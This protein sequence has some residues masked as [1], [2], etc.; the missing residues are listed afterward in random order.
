VLG[1]RYRVLERLAEGGMGTVYSAEHLTLHKQVALKLVHE[2][3]NADHAR[4]FVREAMVTSRIDHPNVISALDFGTFEDGTAYL[5]MQLVDGPTL[6][7]VLSAEGCLSWVRAAE[8]GAQLADALLAAQAHGIVHRDLKPDNVILQLLGDGTELIKV[9][10]FGIAK[11]ARESLAPPSMRGTHVVTRIGAVVGTPGY[12]APEQAVGKRADHRADL[13]ALGV[14][15]WECVVGRR[16]WDFDDLQKLLGAQLSRPAPSVR[17]AS[18]DFTIPD[19]FDQLVA[20]LLAQQANDRPNSAADVRDELRELVLGVKQGVLHSAPRSSPRPPPVVA[21]EPKVPNEGAQDFTPEPDPTVRQKHARAGALEVVTRVLGPHE[22][23]LA[24]ARPLALLARLRTEALRRMRFARPKLVIAIGVMLMIASGVGLGLRAHK[25]TAPHA[26]K[27][28]QRKEVATVAPP[29]KVL[30]DPVRDKLQTLI[31]GTT[32]E[33]RVSNAQALL[34]H[35]PIEEVPTYARAM[36]RIQLAE[37]CAQK[38]TELALFRT[39]DD[40]RTLP[41]LVALSQRKRSGC[42]RRGR[43]DCLGCLRSEL[44]QLIRKLET[45]H[46]EQPR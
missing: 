43:E 17:E 4:R 33:E 45:E 26:V 28:S 9:L 30:V 31:E 14:L 24:P 15:L 27:P 3:D 23:P 10:D 7:R 35:V 11:Y 8:I 37:T 18:Q 21:P 5:T 12:M 40:P 41:V 16:L 2:A 42:G 1:G 22:R 19:A 25:S 39:L 38:K 46:A 36:A 44:A 6:A 29:P 20:R 13:Y 32:R 34:R